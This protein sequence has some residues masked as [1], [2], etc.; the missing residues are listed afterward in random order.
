MTLVVNLYQLPAERALTPPDM[1][2]VMDYVIL[3]TRDFLLFGND[4]CVLRKPP[5]L[6]GP[7]RNDSTQNFRPARLSKSRTFLLKL[8]NKRQFSGIRKLF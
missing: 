4:D 8:P 3:S 5:R 2:N 6:L 1:E 7:P